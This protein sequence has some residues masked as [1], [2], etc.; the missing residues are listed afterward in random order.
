MIW[1]PPSLL[2]TSTL[3]P[4]FSCRLGAMIRARMSLPA[5]AAD[6]TINSMVSPS[7]G[8]AAASPVEEDDEPLP[9]CRR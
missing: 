9:N 4:S 8:K 1:P 2:M 7:T 5:P 6:G 3:A